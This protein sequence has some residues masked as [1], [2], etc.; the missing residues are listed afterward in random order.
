MNNKNY[1]GISLGVI[2]LSLLIL[3]LA[4]EPTSYLHG[5][6]VVAAKN[7]S[8]GLIPWLGFN[9]K[10]M[11]L[12]ISL[13]NAITDIE[14]NHSYARS[15]ILL[16]NLINTALLFTLLKKFGASKQA[17]FFGGILYIAML[18]PFG[19]LGITIEP[20]AVIF[21]LLSYFG[22]L[23][24]QKIKNVFAGIML[25]MAIFVKFE[26]LFFIPCFA[27]LILLPTHR[28]HM[29]LSRT[30]FFLLTIAFFFLISYM[31][32]T[33]WSENMDWIS[34]IDINPL[35]ESHEIG[36]WLLFV[37]SSGVLIQ[38]PF[39]GII[40]QSKGLARNL[41]R[42]AGF[43]M[44]ILIILMIIGCNKSC[45]QIILPLNVIA[46]TMSIQ[47]NWDKKMV[48]LTYATG[49]ALTLAASILSMSNST[50]AGLKNPLLETFNIDFQKQQE[51]K[52][53]DYFEINTGIGAG[54][55]SGD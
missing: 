3:S 16:I 51:I 5:Y 7:W 44:L 55:E 20:I 47:N 39:A 35:N 42:S 41:N 49:F 33:L 10:E 11:P 6:Y 21:I 23:S 37:L 52:S 46:I 29:H 43:G 50:K 27:M 40:Q 14:N 18:S 31:G 2:G 24:H 1:I 38:I 26:V 32:I 8:L 12:G 30:F 22:L 19:F 48:K 13:L 25:V 17:S 15:L 28:H 45:I 4:V 54:I 53:P 34:S 9:L 36:T